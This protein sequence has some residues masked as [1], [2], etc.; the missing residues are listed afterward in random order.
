MKNNEKNVG[1]QNYIQVEIDN[2]PTTVMG[3]FKQVIKRTFSLE[4]FK[5]LSITFGIMFKALFKKQMHTVKYP[6][7]KLP[8]L[9]VFSQDISI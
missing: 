7:E 2:Y 6:I 4:L 8:I 1:T 3:S 5:G 9:I